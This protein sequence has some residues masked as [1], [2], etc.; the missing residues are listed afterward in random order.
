MTSRKA[1][2]PKKLKIDQ[3]SSSRLEVCVGPYI[4]S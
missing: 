3:Y 1:M 2:G 4:A